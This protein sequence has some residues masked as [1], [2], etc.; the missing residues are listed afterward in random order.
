MRAVCKLSWLKI[1][2]WSRRVCWT[3]ITINYNLRKVY[4]TK[5]IRPRL[6]SLKSGQVWAIEKSENCALPYKSCKTTAENFDRHVTDVVSK[7]FSTRTLSA[8]PC[9]GCPRI[10][11][12][13]IYGGDCWP[14]P[15]S[16]TEF[17][18]ASDSSSGSPR[19]WLFFVAGK[20]SSRLRF[21]SKYSN[22]LIEFSQGQ[23]CW[24]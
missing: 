5:N 18:L 16:G 12:S 7:L 14:A 20:D 19:H 15:E 17:I 3:K 13:W 11:S 22:S 8:F 4:Q 24:P 6:E 9:C 10:S 21:S 1:W 23:N 2:K